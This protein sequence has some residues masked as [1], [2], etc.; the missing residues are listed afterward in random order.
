MNGVGKMEN[1][2]E[3]IDVLEPLEIECKKNE[4]CS[5][6]KYNYCCK[7]FLS[8]TPASIVRVLKELRVINKNQ[9]IPN[10]WIIKGE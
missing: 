9:M 7:E 3:V 8:M 6:C 2:R 5:D 4:L 1:I 10:S